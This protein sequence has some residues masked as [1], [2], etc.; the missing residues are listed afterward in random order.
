MIVF[1]SDENGLKVQ[2]IAIQTHTVLF[3]TVCVI[4]IKNTYSEC[5]EK[6]LLYE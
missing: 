2:Y 6:E 3:L 1:S 4:L 5:P